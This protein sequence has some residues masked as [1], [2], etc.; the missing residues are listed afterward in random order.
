MGRQN[1]LFARSLRAG[2]RAAAVMCLIHSANLN[3]L[4]PY[5]YSTMSSI[6]CPHNGR[7]GFWH[8]C[9]IDGGR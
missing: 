3:G 2:K 4:D 9:R 7:I 6:R 8:F 1:W 5:A